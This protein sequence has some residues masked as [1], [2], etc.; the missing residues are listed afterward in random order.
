MGTR[1]WVDVTCPR[2]GAEHQGV[3]YA[4]TCGVKTLECDC[5]E[6][7]DLEEATGITEE[8]ASNRRTLSD[9]VRFYAEH[10]HGP[11]SLGPPAPYY[12][13]DDIERAK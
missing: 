4:P 10:G 9:L 3:W 2:C 7:I 13:R 12:T 8:E 6:V 1:Y 11:H 5:G